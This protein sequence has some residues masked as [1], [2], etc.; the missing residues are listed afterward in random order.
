M[1]SVGSIPCSLWPF[2][3]DHEDLTL[4]S[5]HHARWPNIPGRFMSQCDLSLLQREKIQFTLL[6]LRHYSC[7]DLA[8]RKSSYLITKV[9]FYC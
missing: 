3:S 6:G 5:Y 7:Q 4:L 2:C 8:P 1:I 9:N